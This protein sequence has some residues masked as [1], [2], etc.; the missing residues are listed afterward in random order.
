MIE[1]KID[2]LLSDNKIY[3][4][5]DTYKSQDLSSTKVVLHFGILKKELNIELTNR[6]PAGQIILPERLTSTISLPNLPYESFFKDDQFHLGPV[7]G[8]MPNTLYLKNPSLLM[9]RFKNYNKIKGLIMIFKEKDLNKKDL[10][11]NGYYYNPHTAELTKGTF[12]YPSAVFVRARM[13]KKKLR[14]LKSLGINLFNYPQRNVNKLCFWETVSQNQELKSHLPYTCMYSGT[15]SAE[16]MLSNCSAIY[17]KPLNKSG[18]R[19]IYKLEKHKSAFS[20]TDKKGNISRLDDLSDLENIIKTQKYLMQQEVPV[21]FINKKV[22]FRIYMQRGYDAKWKGTAI[23]ARIAKEDSIITN[24]TGR[25]RVLPGKAAMKEIYGMFKHE[26]DNKVS[27]ITEL[28][29]EALTLLE[30]QGDHYGDAAFDF[31]IDS[32]MKVW[33]LEV[34]I[35]YAA[36]RKVFWSKEDQIILPEVLPAPFEYAKALAGF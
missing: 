35:R 19:G 25:E 1:I 11:I 34:Q 21:P 32:R 4:S 2:R 9:Q 26:I 30:Q 14:H 10:T 16:Q 7:I 24:S 18:G 8:F 3:M 28:C 12:P 15:S 5:E 31:I 20:L 6:L 27:E 33:L 22:D 36:E 17:L 13:T 29:I 23:E